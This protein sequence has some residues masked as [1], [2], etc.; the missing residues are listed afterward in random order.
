MLKSPV[1]PHWT[2]AEWERVAWAVRF[3]RGADPG[4]H[5]KRFALLPPD[6]Q[7]RICLLAGILRLAIAA[8]K[9]GVMKSSALKIEPLPHALLL[10]LAGVE[11]SPR[12]AARFTEAKQ[13]LERSIGKTILIQPEPLPQIPKAPEEVQTAMPISIVR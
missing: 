3:Q 5:K 7:S 9:C 10:R 2:F 13:L 8:Q 12:N 6:Q 1:P 4:S 11:D